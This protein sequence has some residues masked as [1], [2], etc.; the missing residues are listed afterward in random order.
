MEWKTLVEYA[1][2]INKW[3]RASGSAL[4][5]M[6]QGEIVCEHYAGYHS[7]EAGARPVGADSQFNV[8]SARKSYIGLAAA[9]AVREGKIGSLD[10]A[11]TDYLPELDAALLAGTTIR[12]LVTHTHGLHEDTAGR[13]FREFAPGTSWAYRGVNVVMLTDIIE[14][15]TG[16]TV[17][18]ILQELVFAPLGLTQTGWRTEASEQLVKVILDTPQE[19]ELVLGTDGSGGGMQR[20]L[21]VSARDFAK[22]G[23]LHLTQGRVDGRQVVSAGI[24]Q[25]ATSVQSPELPD[26]DLPPNGFFWYVQDRP[27]ARSEIGSTVPQ[28]AF[29][30]LGV[31]GPL[32]LVVPEHELVVVRMSNKRYNYSGPDGDYLHYLREFGD[33]VMEC[34]R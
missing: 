13:L 3:N 8:A 34:V 30:I 29:Q 31:T 32:V 19:T 27:A 2:S 28:G 22:W 5:V 18:E 15:V 11:V 6:R 24:V 23:Q 17:A 33:R 9:W 10:D 4:V 16:K 7:Y 20:N 12:H 21:F 26:P 1:D 14:R 25:L